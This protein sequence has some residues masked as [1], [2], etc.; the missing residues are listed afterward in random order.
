MAIRFYMGDP[1]PAVQGCCPGGTDAYNTINA[2]LHPGC[3]NEKDKAAEGR[4]IELEGAAHLSSYLDMIRLITGAMERYRKAHLSDPDHLHPAYR[5]DRASSLERY[6][7]D[8]VIYGFFSACRE[9]FLPQYAKKKDRIVMLEVLRDESLPYLDFAKLFG[10]LYAK[11]EEAEIMM[12]YGARISSLEEMPLTADEKE[13]YAD[14]SGHPPCG[15]YRMTLTAGKAMERSPENDDKVMADI[16]S[17]KMV[18]EISRLMRKLTQREPLT[19]DELH[20][21]CEWKK[22]VMKIVGCECK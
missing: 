9:G 22:R 10:D 12:P 1:S 13:I 3:D 19:G 14:R 20:T 8:G 5:I 17:E 2:L 18:G 21:Y 15:K 6:T 7:A 11:P 16:S 4:V